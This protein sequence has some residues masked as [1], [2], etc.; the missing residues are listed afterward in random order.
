MTIKMYRKCVFLLYLPNNQLLLK[1]VTLYTRST[2]GLLAVIFRKFVR[3][4]ALDG[5]QNNFT[6]QYPEKLWPFTACKALQWVYSQ[7]L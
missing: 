1:K 7:I 2:L 6:T 3:V 4:M 5:C